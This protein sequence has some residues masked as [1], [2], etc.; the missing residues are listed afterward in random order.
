MLGGRFESA[1]AAYGELVRLGAAGPNHWRDY[2]FCL[3]QAGRY[4]EAAGVFRRLVHRNVHAG[5]A[6]YMLHYIEVRKGDLGSA[7]RYLRLAVEKEP[8][9]REYRSTLA[10]FEKQ[11]GRLLSASGAPRD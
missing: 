10:R 9:N 3:Y 11:F 5:F 1:V 8:E 2:G 4:D 7:A 6:A